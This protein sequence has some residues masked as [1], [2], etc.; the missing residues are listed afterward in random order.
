MSVKPLP[1]RETPFPRLGDW[2]A[3]DWR[4]VGASKHEFVGYEAKNFLIESAT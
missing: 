4:R 2:Q 1:E 3:P